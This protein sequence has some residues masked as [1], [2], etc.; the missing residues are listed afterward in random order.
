M[1][2]RILLKETE[3]IGEDFIDNETLFCPQF[4]FFLFWHTYR[5]GKEKACFWDYQS[6]K[7]FIDE[8]RF[9]K[10]RVKKTI[11]TA[12]FNPDEE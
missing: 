2:Y 10:G 7:D 3:V 4:K 11:R 6:C 5:N 12:T 9:P 1:K 8:K